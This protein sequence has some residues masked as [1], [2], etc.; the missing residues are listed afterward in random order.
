[1]AE[2]K[3]AIPK[4]T[5][6]HSITSLFDNATGFERQVLVDWDGFFKNWI[7][8]V[9]DTD[10]PDGLLMGVGTHVVICGHMGQHDLLKW[11]FT[12]EEPK[13]WD[14]DQLVY[15]PHDQD[16]FGPA[17]TSRTMA[18]HVTF[19]WPASLAKDG[20]SEHVQFRKNMQ[21]F[22]GCLL[23]PTAVRATEVDIPGCAGERHWHKGR[24]SMHQNVIKELFGKVLVQG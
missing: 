22:S 23:L 16:G 4:G 2:K 20:P 1:V 13:V 14:F 12:L 17:P 3:L 10:F 8:V 24:T 9:E 19:F 21:K 7:E 15:V 6:M 5:P 11:Y 18:V